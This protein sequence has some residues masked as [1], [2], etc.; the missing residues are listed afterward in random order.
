MILK[1]PNTDGTSKNPTRVDATDESCTTTI[2][3]PQEKNQNF[4]NGKIESLNEPN[5]K[6]DAMNRI[7]TT[8]IV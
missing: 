2:N 8:E 3:L 5:T 1:T 4:Q 6:N 7:Q